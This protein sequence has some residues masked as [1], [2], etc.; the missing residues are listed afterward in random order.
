MNE[1]ASMIVLGPG[2]VNYFDFIKS[3]NAQIITFDELVANDDPQDKNVLIIRHDIDDDL[4]RSLRF[5]RAESEAGIKAT[6][7]VL[8]T[9]PYF[10]YSPG[11]AAKL[12]EF[13]TLGH[14]VGF[15]DNVLAA[16]LAVEGRMQFKDIIGPPLHFLREAC[17]LTINGMAAHGE[18][19][20]KENGCVNYELWQGV[21][22]ENKL[23]YEQLDMRDFGFNYEAYHTP[24][25][26]YFS[27]SGYKWTTPPAEL[28]KR[29][30]LETGII[31][32]MLAHPQWWTV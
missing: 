12:K 28:K 6:Y 5:A 20:C 2:E 10:D 29:L 27:D 21:P 8:F 13:E 4:D 3:L 22:K 31:V 32:Q 24:K 16:W 23:F 30:D 15:H 14:N 25:H 19:I 1:N 9:H 18:G 26:I 17:K 7:F 11:L